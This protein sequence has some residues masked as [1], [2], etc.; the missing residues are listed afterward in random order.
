MGYRKQSSLADLPVLTS[1]GNQTY[2]LMQRW[3]Q[4]LPAKL[5]FGADPW[6]IPGAVQGSVKTAVAQF[7]DAFKAMK[8]DGQP[9]KPDV[10]ETLAWDPA[11][12]F[13]HL[14]RV[15]GLN[16][17]AAQYRDSWNSFTAGL[18]STGSTTLAPRTIAD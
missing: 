16:A 4:I 9:V 1:N 17:S 15:D 10:G 8:V 2:A 11:R 5:Y 12:L 18:G 6:A 7:Y 3:A 13:I 14:L